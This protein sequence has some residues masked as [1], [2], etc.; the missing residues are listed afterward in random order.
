[1]GCGGW[2]SGIGTGLSYI[3]AAVV[4]TSWPQKRLSRRN[5]LLVHLLSIPA[6]I[7]TAGHA[8]MVGS[9]RHDVWFQALLALLTGLAVYPSVLRLASV[10]DKRAAVRRRADAVPRQP[11]EAGSR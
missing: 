11:V 6:T 4:F 2:L 8:W 1:M 9:N 3:F 10:R 7:M 5:W